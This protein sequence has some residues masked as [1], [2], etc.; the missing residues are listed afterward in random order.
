MK[1]WNLLVWLSQLGLN[2]AVPPAVFLWLAVWLR[3]RFDWGQWII[4]VAAVLG[5]FCAVAGFVSSLRTLH[6]FTKGKEPENKAVSFN[7]HE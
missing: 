2:V 1:D 5:L 3:G 7:E 6:R 4:W